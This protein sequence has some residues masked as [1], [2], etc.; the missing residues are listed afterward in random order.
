MA[1]MLPTWVSGGSR[2]E[3]VKNSLNLVECLGLYWLL[4]LKSVGLDCKLNKIMVVAIGW[5]LAESLF[6]HT[7]VLFL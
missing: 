2:A 1:F 7:L 6:N 3:L 4:T 5:S